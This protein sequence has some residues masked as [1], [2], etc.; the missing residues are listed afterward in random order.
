MSRAE[1]PSARALAGA[2]SAQTHH[3][4][5]PIHSIVIAWQVSEL[6]DRKKIL[7]IKLI[8]EMLA[9]YFFGAKKGV[10]SNKNQIYKTA[11]YYTQKVGINREVSRKK[12]DFL[13][14]FK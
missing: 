10:F 12:Q 11:S 13:L 9:C 4:Y 6:H 8:S 14:N 7:I 5:L 1:N 2:S 3:Y